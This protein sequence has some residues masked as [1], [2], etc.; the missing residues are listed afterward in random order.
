MNLTAV[1]AQV[2]QLPLAYQF[3][4]T[5]QDKQYVKIYKLLFLISKT[6]IFTGKQQQL[7]G[8]D[9][10]DGVLKDIAAVGANAVHNV[11]N[12]LLNGCRL[13]HA[14]DN[15]QGFEILNDG[16]GPLIASNSKPVFN[17]GPANAGV[18]SKQ[19]FRMPKENADQINKE[20][21]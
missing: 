17:G 1:K 16:A 20:I 8:N 18:V 5:F 9:P 2:N 6:F 13:A 21:C 19:S 11:A 14:R 15:L 12:Y 10:A 7:T 4:K 3:A